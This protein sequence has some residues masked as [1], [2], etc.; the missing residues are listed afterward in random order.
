MSMQSVH[1]A[2]E[3]LKNLLVADRIEC[4]PEAA[5]RLSKDIFYTV[6]KHIE[7]EPENIRVSISRS[8]IHIQ[9]AGEKL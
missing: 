7:V 3:R 4:T 5:E 9:F 1:I 6:A 2:K 8:D